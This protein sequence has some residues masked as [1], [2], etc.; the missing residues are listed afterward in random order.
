MAKSDEVPAEKEKR[1]GAG[2]GWQKLWVIFIVGCLFGY[3]YE[4]ILNFFMHLFENGEIF[5]ERRSGV[6]YG[7]FSVIY[8]G[9]A[10]LMAKVLAE[11]NLKWWQVFLYGALLCGGCEY[12]IGWLQ[13]IFTG[14]VSWDYSDHWMNFNGRTS[15]RILLIWGIVAVVFIQWIYPWVDKLCAKIPYKIGGKILNVVVV[16]LCLDMLLSFSAMVRMSWRHDGVPAYTPY[17]KFL[18]AVY[19]DERMKQAYP[20]TELISP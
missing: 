7:P 19:T 14:T 11:K 17:G 6:L 10:V 8:G 3:F 16:L 20:N 12:L 5:L 1:F 15:P 18:D 13:E 2:L 9:G 4:V